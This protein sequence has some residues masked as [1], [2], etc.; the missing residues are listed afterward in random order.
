MIPHEEL[1]L[2]KHPKAKEFRPVKRPFSGNLIGW[3]FQIP[4]EGFIS[5]D[6]GWV[7]VSGDVSSDT[8]ARSNDAASNLRA[9]VKSATTS[10]P[11]SK[12]DNQETGE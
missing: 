6:Y 8:L 1:V 9:Y 5:C 12:L 11:K 4:R 7:T 2:A 3:I 10:A